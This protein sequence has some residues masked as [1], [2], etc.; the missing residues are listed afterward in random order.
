MDNQRDNVCLKIYIYIYIAN[1]CTSFYLD[2][3]LQRYIER[4]MNCICIYFEG[5]Y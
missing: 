3:G 1:M 2:N 5:V 4:M